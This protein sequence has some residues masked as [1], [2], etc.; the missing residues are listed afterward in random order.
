[1]Q[2]KRLGP[3]NCPVKSSKTFQFV[4][5]KAHEIFGAEKVTSFSSDNLR[6]VAG[7]R[8]AFS[9]I[10]FINKMVKVVTSQ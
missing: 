4:F 5:L 6:V 1:M 10:F 2:Q 3:E 7:S 9:G 8:K